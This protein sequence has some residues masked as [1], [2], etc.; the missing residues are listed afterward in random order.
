MELW[1]GKVGMNEAADF[2]AHIEDGSYAAG[3]V[4]LLRSSFVCMKLSYFYPDLD[5][6]ESM[7]HKCI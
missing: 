1:S 4:P 5:C 6:D 3:Q 2:F 7:V